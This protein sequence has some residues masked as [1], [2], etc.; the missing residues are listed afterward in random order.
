ML[1]GGVCIH[2][3]E[4]R[5][6]VPPEC[7]YRHAFSSHLLWRWIRLACKRNLRAD[8]Q[9]DETVR[10]CYRLIE[11]ALNPSQ[12]LTE[13]PPGRVNAWPVHG[14]VDFWQWEAI[15]Q[16]HRS[17]VGS[18][19]A[20][21]GTTIAVDAQ[22]H[23]V[24]RLEGI[25]QGGYRLVFTGEPT[26]W[27]KSGEKDRKGID[28]T[29]SGG[30]GV[31]NDGKVTSV[32]WDSAAFNAGMTVGTQI[33]AV[34]GRTFDADGLKRAIKNAAAS[35]RAAELLIKSGDVYRT[36][37]LDW[38]G[39]LRYPRLEKVGTGGGTLDALLAPR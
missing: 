1:Q 18:V 22:R 7:P 38:H 24:D 25:A 4:A 32:L 29:Y 2:V 20:K 27:W 15:K 23:S 31:G 26:K 14:R 21:P 39:G 37:S 5:R 28:L 36:V 16:N 35:G 10:G 11:T 33:V 3:G 8:L 30:F 13:R 12:L 9:N 17:L 34:N 6:T 19:T